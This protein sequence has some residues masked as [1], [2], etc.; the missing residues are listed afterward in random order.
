MS[1]LDPELA[2]LFAAER[3]YE[4]A[5]PPGAEGRVLAR[6][7]AKLGGGGD[8]PDGGAAPTRP[9][10][11]GR[12]VPLPRAITGMI[13][14]AV[15]GAFVGGAIMR[16]EAPRPAPPE[17]VVERVPQPS[18]PPRAIEV[19]PDMLP[20][21]SPA[22]AS[23]TAAPPSTAS[24]G[25]L[26]ARGLTAERAL[27][28]TARVALAQGDADAALDAIGRHEREFAGGRLAEERDALAVRA[29]VK[30][31]KNDE[32]RA[33]GERFLRTYPRSLAAPAVRAALASIP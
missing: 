30:A 21:A 1:D 18:P 26:D 8:G 14:T 11:T 33:R 3:G 7:H 24:A 12:T 32:A 17:I 29:L 16:R 20:N 2:D 5:P 28:D 6:V 19:V 25:A 13:G 23:G 22:P 31:G 10:P 9:T 27:L 15:I 4:E